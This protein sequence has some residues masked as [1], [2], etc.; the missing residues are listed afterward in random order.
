MAVS[1]TSRSA[2]SVSTEW[3]VHNV[4]Q[5]GNL[6]TALENGLLTSPGRSC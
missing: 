5:V 4:S 1:L 3:A 2:T 6:I